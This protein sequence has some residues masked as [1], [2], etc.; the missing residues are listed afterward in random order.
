MQVGLALSAAQCCRWDCAAAPSVCQ[1]MGSRFSAQN[2]GVGGLEAAVMTM[3][4]QPCCRDTFPW[5]RLLK[6][7]NK[8]A[9]LEVL[10]QCELML[11]TES[12][13]QAEL[14]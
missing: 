8:G 9:S 5:T 14:S 13:Q 10:V 12:P 6:W 11:D 3:Q 2:H 4:L 1:E 7:G